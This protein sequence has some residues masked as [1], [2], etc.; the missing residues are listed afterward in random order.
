MQKEIYFDNGATTKP[1]DD[2][3]KYMCEVAAETYG[4]PSSLHIMGI[5]AERLVRK[6]RE[7]IAGYLSCDVKEI[8]FT[9]G[10]TESNNLAIRG[11]LRANPRK[12]KHI[13]TSTIEHPSVLEVY[14]HLSENGY[15]V[16]YIN[17][18]SS[19]RIILD[20][21]KSKIKKD[22]ALIS[23]I[24][25]NNEVGSIQPIEDI[26]RIKNEIN[27]ETVL[28]V[29]AVQ[30]FGKIKIN[31][32]KSGIDLLSGS[33]HK[34]H[35][36][37]GAGCL[38]AGR[39]IRIKPIVFGGGQEALL[40]SGTENVPAICGFGMA[41]DIKSANMAEDWN[42]ITRLKTMFLERLKESTLDFVIN[43]DN[44]ASPYVLN[45]SFSDIRSEVLLHHLEE[46]RIFVST[47]SACSSRKNVHSHVL[48]AMG[49]KPS[50]IDG[51]IRFSFSA[52]NNGEDIEKTIEALKEIVPRIRINKRAK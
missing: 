48:K 36:P 39:K 19:G 27:P 8:I 23:I 43:S 47:G 20:E 22:T 28:H 50:E 14:K 37:K 1:Y 13:I 26:V 11:Y 17:V 12:G 38:Y 25:V 21:L 30:S 18:D 44:C 31:P 2:V 24:H 29:D 40:R 51:A 16:D 32:Q 35:G 9:S 46:K 42:S 7:S 5:E 10:G 33:S 3:I 49:K 15:T 6:A 34:V 45:I 52:F 4:N 41:C